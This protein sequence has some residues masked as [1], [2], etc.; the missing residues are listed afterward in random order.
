VSN[1]FQLCGLY[2]GKVNKCGGITTAINKS[3]I[4]ASVYVSALGIVGDQCADKRHHG[5]LERAL[6]QYP[7]EHYQYW[8]QNYS[9]K[10]PWQ[11]PG[12]GENLSSLGMTEHNVCIGDRYQWGQAIIEVSQPRSPCFKL[13]KHWGI[14]K[15]SLQMQK[16]SL[17]GWLYR[18]IKP[19]IVSVAEPLTLLQRPSNAMTVYQVCE[20]FF[21]DPLNQVGL[22]QLKE[23]TKLSDSWMTKVAQRLATNQVENWHYR[24]LGPET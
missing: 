7:V 4:S 6:H 9:S 20:L 15:F 23:Q 17:C 14:D 16:L 2:A 11:A 19:G 8:R 21:G 12:M 22:L 3:L 5:G 1:H 13:N 10:L 24:L 18:V